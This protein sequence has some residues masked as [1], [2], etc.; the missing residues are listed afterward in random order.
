MRIFDR[1]V[2]FFS[3]I[4]TVLAC[5]FTLLFSKEEKRQLDFDN[6]CGEVNK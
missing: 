2:D 6:G 5:L 4:Y 1:I 3:N